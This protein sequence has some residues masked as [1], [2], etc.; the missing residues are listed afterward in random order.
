M[1]LNFGVVFNAVLIVLGILWCRQVFGRWRRDLDEFR[2]TKETS[3][4]IVLIV[5]W[6][7]TAN[8]T[9]FL[10]NSFAGIIRNFGAW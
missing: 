10:L 3:T 2:S 8:I 4:R 5:I 6:F 1:L 9:V 7:L